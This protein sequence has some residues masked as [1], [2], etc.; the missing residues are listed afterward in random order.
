MEESREKKVV[1]ALRKAPYGIMYGFEG[2]RAI[3]GISIFEM[4][5]IPV[6]LDDGV[7][8]AVRNQDP[9][10]LEMNP[11]GDSFE[12]LDDFGVHRTYVHKESLAK[13][14]LK[15]TDM[16]SGIRIAGTEEIKKIFAEADLILP[17]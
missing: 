6:L 16:V 9:S 5:V 13:R 15:D 1:I 7:Y 17:F 3:M 12:N 8:A 2:L 4:D 11:L 10:A 14:G